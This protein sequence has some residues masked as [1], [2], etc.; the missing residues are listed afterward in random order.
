MPDTFT[1]ELVTPDKLLLSTQAVYVNAPGV[2]GDFGVLP[3]HMPF[4]SL[5][6]E[7]SVLSI[8]DE[9]DKTHV[10]TISGGLAQVTATSVTILA[11]GIQ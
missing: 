7:D 10:F 2:E 6:R 3:G 11:E 8:N 4:V 1:F 9:T 5:L